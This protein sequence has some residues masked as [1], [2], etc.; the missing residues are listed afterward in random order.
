MPKKGRDVW[1]AQADNDG[2]SDRRQRRRKAEAD[3]AAIFNHPVWQ[4]GAKLDNF[5]LALKECHVKTEGT[6]AEMEA[7]L[8]KHFG[9]DAEARDNP[10]DWSGLEDVCHLK[11]G[12]LC[13]SEESTEMAC[14]IVHN[15]YGCLRKHGHTNK[16]KKLPVCV[17]V[18]FTGT[19]RETILVTHLVGMGEFIGFLRLSPIEP[20]G[21]RLA[22]TNLREIGEV[23]VVVCGSL[24]MLVQQQLAARE[25]QTPPAVVQVR[26]FAIVDLGL[27]EFAFDTHQTWSENVDTQRRAATQVNKEKKSESVSLGF[28][29]QVTIGETN[30]AKKKRKRRDADPDVEHDI[31][32]AVASSSG[33]D[34]SYKLA[35]SEETDVNASES[36]S[37]SLG[38]ASPPEPQQ[39]PASDKFGLQGYE[40]GFFPFRD[41]QHIAFVRVD[42]SKKKTT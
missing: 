2:V 39:V 36:D 11:Y 21:F 18:G 26:G 38:E 16:T 33:D 23:E 6:N 32:S 30:S 22:K 1:Q 7:L 3:A 28:G 8:E 41:F 34:G 37:D 25:G 29:I 5:G 17:S 15:V 24:H 19:S 27:Q 4:S 9:F 31:Q 20:R 10:E 13:I 40:A 35:P 42:F 14:T 12:G